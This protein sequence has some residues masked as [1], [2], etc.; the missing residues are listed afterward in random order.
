MI[1][2]AKLFLL[3]F[4]FQACKTEENI[5]FVFPIRYDLDVF[6]DI[7]SLNNYHPQS[8]QWV[9]NNA[10]CINDTRLPCP[11]DYSI[12]ALLIFD[13]R[14]LAQLKIDYAKSKLPMDE[15][16]EKFNFKWLNKTVK[17]KKKDKNPCYH[18]SFFKDYYLGNFII[19]SD[20]ELLVSFWKI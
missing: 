17:S 16:C 2:V 5:S 18:L 3:I 8:V 14:D 13:K 10:P 15:T 12:E 9:I 6:S 11:N 7:I 19:I 4:M 20:E 1:R